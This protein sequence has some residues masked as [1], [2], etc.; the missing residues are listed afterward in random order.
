MPLISLLIKDIPK[1]RDLMVLISKDTTTAA[2]LLSER[3]PSAT[4]PKIGTHQTW[5]TLKIM[6]Q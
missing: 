4:I 3:S 2:S 1:K 5:D 6:V